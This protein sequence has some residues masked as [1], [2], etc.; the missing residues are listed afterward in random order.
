M[1]PVS[2]TPRGRAQRH[3]ALVSALLIGE[4][5]FLGLSNGGGWIVVAYVLCA[6]GAVLALGVVLDLVAP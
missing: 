2:A 1:P 6:A 5:L 3:L 4:G